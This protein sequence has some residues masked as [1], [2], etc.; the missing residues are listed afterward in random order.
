MSLFVYWLLY[1]VVTEAQ[2][3]TRVLLLSVVGVVVLSSFVHAFRSIARTPEERADGQPAAFRSDNRLFGPPSASSG[4]T[5]G[6]LG[7]AGSVIA[8]FLITFVSMFVVGHVVVMFLIS[9]Q[10]YATVE[11]YLAV[12]EWEGSR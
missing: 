1:I 12:R 10:R 3:W 4:A 5:A 9:F 2:S 6:L 7:Y 8:A 11:E